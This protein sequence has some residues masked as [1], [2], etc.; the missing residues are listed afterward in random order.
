MTALGGICAVSMLLVH[1]MFTIIVNVLCTRSIERAQI[2]PIIS[3][4]LYWLTSLYDTTRRTC[5]QQKR[6]NDLNTD[7][8]QVCE[9]LAEGVTPI[10]THERPLVDVEPLLRCTCA[11]GYI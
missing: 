6:H 10:P 11:Q 1:N 4:S 2:P 9:Q 3:L 5:Q 7:A 8:R